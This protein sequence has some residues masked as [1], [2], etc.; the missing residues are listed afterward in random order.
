[1]LASPAATLERPLRNMAAW[2]AYFRAAE[3]PVLP[4]TAEMIEAWRANEDA[5]DAHL[6]AQT[7]SK[8]PLMTLKLM[9][10]VSE[11]RARRGGTDIETVTAA[12]VML[13]MGP[14]FHH[15]GPQPTVDE[16]LR[17]HPAAQQGLRRVL[18]RSH[19]AAAFALGFAVHRMDHDASVIHEAALLHDFAEMLLWVHAPALALDIAAR[20]RAQPTLRS[21]SVQQEVLNT[22]LA[23]LQQ[24]LMRTWGLSE[25]LVRITDDSHAEQAQVRNVTL[26]VRLARHTASGWDDP[27]LADDVTDIAALL[28]MGNLPTLNLLHEI[29]ES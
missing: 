27:A 5:C 11:L 7:L 20:Q 16:H 4:N 15:F 28:N 18:R 9:A 17:E 19:R 2:T 29:D 3:I 14:F 22:E 10:K 26:A 8:D 6:L 23:P 1:M 21:A 25:L 13:G 12:L 24:A